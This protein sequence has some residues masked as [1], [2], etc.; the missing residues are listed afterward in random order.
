MEIEV[1]LKTKLEQLYSRVESLKEQIKTEEATKNAFI[2]PFLQILGYDV[3]NPTEVIPE[4]VA[5]IGTQKRRKS[6]LRNQ[7]RRSS[8]PNRRMQTL[9]R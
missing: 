6:R 5:D 7:E 4:F 2:M 9:E 8:Y 3:F 1:E